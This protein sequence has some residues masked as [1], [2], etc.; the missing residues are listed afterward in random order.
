MGN[1]RHALKV[2]VL[3]VGVGPE[4]GHLTVIQVAPSTRVT[5][6]PSLVSSCSPMSWAPRGWVLR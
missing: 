1:L 2:V 4:N 6:K 3:V 5:W